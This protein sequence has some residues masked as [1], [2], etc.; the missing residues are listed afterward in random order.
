MLYFSCKRININIS[1][2]GALGKEIISELGRVIPVIR[3]VYI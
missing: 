2:Q 1:N 3:K